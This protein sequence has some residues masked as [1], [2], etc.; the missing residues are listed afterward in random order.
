MHLPALAV[1]IERHP[2]GEPAQRHH[3][4]LETRER[5]RRRAESVDGAVAR[6]D[7]EH[8]PAAREL[9]DAGDG[10]GGDHEG[11]GEGIGDERSHA[12]A[13]GVERG[14]G[15]RHVHLAEHGLRIGHAEQVEAVLLDIAA[16]GREAVERVR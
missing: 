12:D 10:A 15:E 14:E 3:G 16:Q 5:G 9:V 6:A 4:V 1:A 13:R 2:A 7:P 8:G 11:P